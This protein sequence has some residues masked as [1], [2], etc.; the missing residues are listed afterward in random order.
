[1]YNRLGILI[2]IHFPIENVADNSYEIYIRVAV[3]DP[4]PLEFYFVFYRY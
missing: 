1:M 2:R 3:L 4:H